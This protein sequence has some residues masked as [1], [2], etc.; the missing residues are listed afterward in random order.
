MRGVLIAALLVLAPAACKR[1]TPAAP[2][3]APKPRL[4]LV[5]VRDLTPPESAPARLDTDALERKVRERLLATGQFQAD[6]ARADGGQTAVTRAV[7]QLGIDAAEVGEKGV[8]R[9]RVAIRLDTRPSDAPGAI[10]ENLEAAAEQPYPVP[11]RGSERDAGAAAARQALF[12]RLVLRMTTDLVDGFGAKRRLRTAAPAELRAAVKADGGELRLE[13]IRAIGERKLAGEGDVLLGLLDDDD[14]T[15]RDAAL[16]ALIALG[17]RRAVTSLT[18][19]RSL[20]DRREMRKI[21][22]A[23]SILGGQEADDYLAFV[24]S[25]HDDEEIRA[26]AAAARARLQRRQADAR[27]N[28]P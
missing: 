18:R 17:D 16:G 7:A 5:T 15:T 28:P 11:R 25:S 2:P 8:A 12:E 4:G 20:R 21:I 26:D 13:A 24:A 9:A 1:T 19:S 27:P 14:E 6:A 10:E 22:E 23:I 3:P